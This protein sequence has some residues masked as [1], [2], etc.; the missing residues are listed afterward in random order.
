LTKLRYGVI[1]VFS[2]GD[3]NY[4]VFVPYIKSKTLTTDGEWETNII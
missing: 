3:R 1:M 2:R 4:G